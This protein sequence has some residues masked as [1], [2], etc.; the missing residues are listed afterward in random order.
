MD[1]IGHS[2]G[3]KA[4]M[5]LALTQPDRVRRLIVA[6]MAPVSYTHTH[7][8]LIDA[9]LALDLSD[10]RTRGH[11]DRAFR[12]Y[13]FAL[14]HYNACRRCPR[15]RSPMNQTLKWIFLLLRRGSTSVDQ[16]PGWKQGQCGSAS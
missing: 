1:V 8:H 12:D 11:A 7:A 14:H 16:E 4:A 6:D 13:F 10:V 15:A 3:G 2:M 5:A 9:M